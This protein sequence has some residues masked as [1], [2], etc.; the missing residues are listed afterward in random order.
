MKKFIMFKVLVVSFFIGNE[1]I[2]Q[3][4]TIDME[5]SVSTCGGSFYDSGG[6]SGDYGSSETHTMTFCSDQPGDEIQFNFTFFN[7]E[8]C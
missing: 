5:G 8:S 4:F 3:N 2:G 7:L 6:S 1:A